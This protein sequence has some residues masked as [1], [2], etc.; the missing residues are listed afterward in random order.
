MAVSC[1]QGLVCRDNVLSF[2]NS[3]KH[4]GPGRL[5]TAYEFNKYV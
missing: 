4:K 5:K 2:L 3:L 1:K